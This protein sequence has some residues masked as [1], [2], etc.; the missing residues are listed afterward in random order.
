M[1]K[2]L[3]MLAGFLAVVLSMGQLP[4]FAESTTKVNTDG[5]KLVAAYAD[6]V[7][8]G[9][10]RDLLY[11]QYGLPR[12]YL[13][14]MGKYGN[15][16]TKPSTTGSILRKMNFTEKY[17][18]LE[19]V[20]G[21]SISGNDLWYKVFWYSSGKKR[22]GYIHSAYVAKR[23]YNFDLAYEKA[24]LYKAEVE[25]HRVG[26]ISNFRN[27][28]GAPPKFKGTLEVDPYQVLRYQAAAA[29]TSPDLKS[30][31]RYIQDGRV[32]QIL[33]E[34]GSF[35]EV[36][37]PD[38]KTETEPAVFYI[39]KKYVSETGSNL[40]NL[41]QI[42]FVDRKQQ[43]QM[44][45]SFEKEGWRLVSYTQATTGAKDEFRNPT[46]LGLFMVLNKKPKFDYLDDETKLIDGYAPYAIRFNG[47][48]F[49]HGVPVAY[50]IEKEEKIIKPAVL[51]SN[52]KV[53]KPAVVETK[54]LSKT[55][56]GEVE[57]LSS[58]G[59]VPK[60]HKCVRNYTSHAK[61]LY[62]WIK[63]GQSAVV[64]FE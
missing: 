23:E 46:D 42:I 6:V 56:P 64:V 25:S 3:R 57:Y 60:S 21:Q 63:V 24:Q 32:V 22:L 4:A 26:R 10:K 59:T 58:I 41:N 19:A 34:S 28:N 9:L 31:F 1:I 17:G 50:D 30:D 55:D 44:V 45:L 48:A 2:R 13:V 54:I 16:R 8:S 14:M 18:V 5:Y 33:S 39:L 38:L 40:K 37:V 49:I 36:S 29:Y 20:N 47:G 62:E 35:F 15:I 43:N 53:I 52:G 12:H 61:F 27:V 7:P 11:K 51:D